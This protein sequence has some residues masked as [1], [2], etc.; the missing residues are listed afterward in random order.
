VGR[1]GALSAGPYPPL[2]PRVV[3]GG[4]SG[5]GKTTLAK[6]LARRLGAPHIELDAHYH[7]PGWVPATDEQMTASVGAATAGETWVADGNYS[8]IRPVLWARATTFVWLDY[9]KGIPTWRAV[10]RTIPRLVRRPELWNGNREQWR[11]LFDSGHP[12]WWSWHHHPVQRASYE[13][14]VADPAYAHVDVI[15]L[16]TP[17]ETARWL[18]DVALP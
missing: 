14:S 11:Y 15:R 1:R 17:R 5:C 2:G 3:V 10:R 12:I 16:R 7:Q 8:R 9:R 18:R 4:V 6:E 13:E